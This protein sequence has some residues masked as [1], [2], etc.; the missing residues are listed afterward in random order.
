M[1]MTSPE[2]RKVKQARRRRDRTD[3]ELRDAIGAARAAGCSLQSIADAAN[4][5]RQRVWQIERGTR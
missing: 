4:L 5:T 2:L 1:G 3:D